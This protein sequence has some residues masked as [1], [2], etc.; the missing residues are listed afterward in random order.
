ME[1]NST[2]AG[3]LTPGAVTVLMAVYRG[4][5]ASELETALNSLY[6]QSRP[7]EEILVVRDGPVE[8]GVD[9]LLRDG[10]VETLMLERN[11]GL[12]R[13]LAHGFARVTTEF[14]AR[15]DSDDAATAQRLEKQLEFM[16]AHPEI[17]VVGS[18]MQE[19]SVEEGADGEADGDA[20]KLG[21]VRRLPEEHAQIAQYTRLNSPMNHPSVMMRT[22]AVR[23][24][25][26]YRPMH[27][28]EDY[29]LWARL[30]AAGQRLHNMPEPLT[31]FRVSDAQFRRRT[32]RETR[33]AERAMQDA[34]VSYGLISRPR[35]RVNLAVRN[36]YRAL[37]LGVMRRVYARLFHA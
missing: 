31:Y 26:G 11:Q 16:R 10:R 19:F 14:V 37:P 30:I 20:W 1:K 7:A 3:D 23:A 5:T 15:L 18:A 29:D 34:L 8:G 22:A 6:S 9:K 33:A 35:A 12:G 32:T 24:V 36:L 13:A 25:G 2:G 21:G 27:N 28:M 4:T 17:A